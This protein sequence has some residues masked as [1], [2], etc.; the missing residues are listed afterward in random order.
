MKIKNFLYK[1]DKTDDMTILRAW[2]A[3]VKITL[4]GA[5][6]LEVVK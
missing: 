3:S 1:L 4:I 6:R 2:S 5:N